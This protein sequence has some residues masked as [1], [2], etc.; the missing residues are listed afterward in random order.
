MFLCFV[1]VIDHAF[2]E[3]VY[4]NMQMSVTETVEVNGDE[5]FMACDHFLKCCPIANQ[6]RL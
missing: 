5:L 4:L 1:I 6:Q 2:M 3:N